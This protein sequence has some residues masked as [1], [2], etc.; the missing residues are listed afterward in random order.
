MHEDPVQTEIE[1]VQK[2][3]PLTLKISNRPEW[4][5]L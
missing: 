4:R 3:L 5:A 2:P 1:G